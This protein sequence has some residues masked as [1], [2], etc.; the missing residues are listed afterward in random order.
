MFNIYNSIFTSSGEGIQSLEVFFDSLFF[1]LKVQDDTT[2]PNILLIEKI[3]TDYDLGV[4]T[5]PKPGILINFGD[6]G[7]NSPYCTDGNVYIKS[8]IDHTNKE[9]YVVGLSSF[10]DY[11][12][13]VVYNYN[14]N[15]H[16]ASLKFPLDA[17]LSDWV[18]FTNFIFNSAQFPVASKH[19][20]EINICFN[21]VT[22]DANFINILSLDTKTDNI[23]I[24]NYS[25]ISS[26]P[27]DIVVEGIDNHNCYCKI[28]DYRGSFLYK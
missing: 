24:T 28:G 21:S 20:D 26:M 13:P 7:S 25:M 1:N 19:D 8:F 17:H 12:I 14:I 4:I 16:R 23:T 22:G 5:N 10:S 15:N 11:T 18:G 9:V 6:T 2:N 27:T 3:K